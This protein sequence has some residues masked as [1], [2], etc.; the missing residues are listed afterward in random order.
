MIWFASNSYK[1]KSNI[2]AIYV[3]I[4]SCRKLTGST[5]VKYT[6]MGQRENKMLQWQNIA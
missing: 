4:S 3:V 5:M 6:Q 2:P 1:K